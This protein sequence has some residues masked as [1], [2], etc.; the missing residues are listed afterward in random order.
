MEFSICFVVF[1]LESFPKI[2]NCLIL[3]LYFCVLQD[4][5]AQKMRTVITRS[6]NHS[7]PTT[8][9]T[10]LLQNEHHIRFLY[11]LIF[12]FDSTKKIHFS[13]SAGFVAVLFKAVASLI[14]ISI[15]GWSWEEPTS[16]P[17]LVAALMI[18]W[19]NGIIWIL[20]SKGFREYTFIIIKKHINRRI[21]ANDLVVPFEWN[22]KANHNIKKDF[23]CR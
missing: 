23:V 14:I 8:N 9:H 4:Y 3:F 6:Q 16:L 22:Y 12:Q 11:F 2:L 5:F 21:F 7:L 1:F 19:I 17:I 13:F 15:V 20:L 18:N 10:H